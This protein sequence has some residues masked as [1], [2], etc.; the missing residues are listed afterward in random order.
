MKI[1]LL[2]LLT[3]SLA[4]AQFS[5]SG[6]IVTDSDSSLQWQDDTTPSTKDWQGAIDYCENLSLD[7]Y[8]DWRLPNINELLTIVDDTKHNP[9]LKDSFVYFAK[10]FFW[11]STTYASSTSS[12]WYVLFDYV[13]SSCLDK[14][15]ENYVRCVRAG[16]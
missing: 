8:N 16:E 11:S 10:S 6:N 15:N 1:I 5:R 2:V 14:T 13:Y 4:F 7:G 9:A 12:S 3:V